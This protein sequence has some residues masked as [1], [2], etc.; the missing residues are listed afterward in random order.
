MAPTLEQGQELVYEQ[1]AVVDLLVLAHSDLLVGPRT[2]FQAV[3][4]FTG[5]VLVHCDYT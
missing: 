5:L 3:Y 1:L 2:A 4:H